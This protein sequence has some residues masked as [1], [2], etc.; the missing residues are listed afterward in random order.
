MSAPKLLL[1]L[2]VL[3]ALALACGSS[4]EP[5]SDGGGTTTTTTPA[6]T[7]LP[8]AGT[9]ADP[10]QATC[11]HNGKELVGDVGASFFVKCPADCTTGSV[12]GTGPYTR[13]SRLCTA[14]IHG[15]AIPVGGGVF[16]AS[17]AAGQSAYEGSE[18]NGVK[19]SSWGSY[20]TS[21]AVAAAGGGAKP[22]PKAEEPA[23]RPEPKP[24]AGEARPGGPRK[25]N[26]PQ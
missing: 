23:E 24:G 13:D 22:K 11:N 20:D 6:A 7:S 9:Q 21:L 3:S 25:L 19:S 10:Y 16:K 8:G 2:S 18:A 14:A 1:T 17:I 26:R 12:W 15:G 4:D 5:A